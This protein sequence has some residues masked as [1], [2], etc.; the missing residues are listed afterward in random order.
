MPR[1]D[2]LAPAAD[3]AAFAS[4]CLQA[5]AVPPDDANTTADNL[6]DAHLGGIDSHG[7]ANVLHLYVERLEVGM[8]NPRL[9]L[10]V[11][12]ESDAMALLDGDHGLGAV[13][14]VR[15][16]EL[17]L[18]KARTTGAAW[19]GVRKSNHFGTCAFF[20][21]RIAA[22]GMIGVAFTNTAARMAPW[23]GTV[24]HLG[25][26]P[27]CFS[28]PRRTGGPLSV[29]LATSVAAR[30]AVL[31]AASRGQPIPEHWTLDR[32]GRPTTD[33]QAALDGTVRPMA[34]HKG[35]A[36][37]L[38]IDVL[39]G[40]LTGA[41][42]GRGVGRLLEDLDR[43][44]NVGHLIGA[45][46]IARFLPLDQFLDRLEQFGGEL[47]RSPTAEGVERIL[48]PG[49][50]EAETVECRRREGISMA[51]PLRQRLVLL[52]RRLGVAP[53]QELEAP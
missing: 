16:M 41:A 17:C 29:D 21:N 38:I 12:Q 49:D 25:T 20:T 40:V 44:Q 31:L 45:I 34:N 53:P 23:G 13:A 6:I 26:N 37:A 24:P 2:T 42:W 11:I 33:P 10:R 7:V 19:V 43:P 27:L 3:L 4:R 50:R 30:G 8:V 36:L 46:D 52:G 28:V 47:L 22:E 15:A 35:S 5:V 48:L 14:G 9:S 51:E 39:S 1:P 18:A 32:E